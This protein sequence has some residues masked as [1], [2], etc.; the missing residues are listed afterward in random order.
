[1]ANKP[2]MSYVPSFVPQ[3]LPWYK[4]DDLM[5]WYDQVKCQ[6]LLRDTDRNF[7]ETK[8]VNF[9]KIHKQCRGEVVP[10][11]LLKYYQTANQTRVSKYP[12][13]Y[14]ENILSSTFRTNRKDIYFEKTTE[15]HFKNK[16]VENIK[17]LF[18]EKVHFS[19]RE[20]FVLVLVFDSLPVFRKW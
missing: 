8:I 10:N 5:T 14:Q 16:L 1:M 13:D 11:E 18:L 4:R 15:K 6:D 12:S 20:F 7:D 9:D 3:D 2:A 17:P 19:Y